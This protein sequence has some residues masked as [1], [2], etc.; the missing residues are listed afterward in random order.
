MRPRL[1]TNPDACYWHLMFPLGG[2]EQ[3]TRR[4]AGAQ[5]KVMEIVHDAEWCA[6][7]V[8]SFREYA[9]A[10]G[11]AGMPFQP[12]PVS[13]DHVLAKQMKGEELPDDVQATRAGDVMAV[14]FLTESTPNA[15]A[16]AYALIQWRDSPW[17]WEARPYLSPTTADFHRMRDG[18]KITGPFLAEVGLVALPALETIGSVTDRLELSALPLPDYLALPRPGTPLNEPMTLRE[19]SGGLIMRSASYID[20]DDDMT[21]EQIREIVRAELAL[22]MATY[23]ERMNAMVKRM[24]GMTPPTV[25]AEPAPAEEPPAEE[26][27]ETRAFAIATEIA[28][29]EAMEHLRNKR[30]IPRDVPVYVSRSVN[31]DDAAGLLKDWS[32]MAKPQGHATGT[33]GEAGAQPTIT[34]RQIS[35]EV[36]EAGTGIH[37]RAQ[38]IAAKRA[39][40]I[41]RGY[42][43]TD[44][45]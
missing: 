32:V 36:S 10:S 41:T 7:M 22:A 34:E 43:I 4:V 21:E 29:A 24:D 3:V 5:A 39:D 9:A 20:E 30:L 16:G 26:S 23:D 15:P 11:S 17:S 38:A 27:L 1:I 18:R 45:V 19:Y 35:V 33:P 14:H 28:T 2:R 25:P 6:G 44:E 12:R 40:Y 13:T 31:G 8:R 37:E 42:R